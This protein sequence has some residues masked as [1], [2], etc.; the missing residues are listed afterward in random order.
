MA[1]MK[2]N[3]TRPDLVKCAKQMSFVVRMVA[4]ALKKALFVTSTRI[5]LMGLMRSTV[6]SYQGMKTGSKVLH[7]SLILLNANCI[8]IHGGKKHTASPYCDPLCKSKMLYYIHA[9]T[10]TFQD[11]FDHHIG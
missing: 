7:S 2:R 10:F 4:P 9:E 3:V 1:V 8:F 6:V 11:T 5:A